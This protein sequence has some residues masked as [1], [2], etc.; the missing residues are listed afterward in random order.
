[1]F[2][3]GVGELVLIAIVA[4]LVVGPKKLP[5]A[6][7]AIGKVISEFRRTTNEI[8]TEVAFDDVVDQVTRPLREGMAGIEADVMDMNEP[9]AAAAR[10]LAL[11]YPE[12]GP[13]DH[14]A[15]PE[16]AGVYPAATPTYS[17]DKARALEASPPRAAEVDD[18]RSR[19]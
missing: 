4:L 7:R 8:R 18:D 10:R 11:E 16:S 14:G 19:R 2:G 6:L 17:R 1:M 5:D 13:D 12:G 9:P 15:L 3:I